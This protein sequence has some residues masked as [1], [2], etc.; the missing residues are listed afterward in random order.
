MAPAKLIDPS[1]PETRRDWLSA[2]L[3]WIILCAGA[4]WSGGTDW[5]K[6]ASIRSSPG[7]YPV[8][9]LHGYDQQGRAE[10]SR[11]RPRNRRVFSVYLPVVYRH[12]E[13]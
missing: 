2:L 8:P 1:A 11:P 7:T 12:R 9:E 5:F 3:P 4:A 13:S 10:W 6:A